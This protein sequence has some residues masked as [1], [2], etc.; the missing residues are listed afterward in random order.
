MLADVW[1]LYGGDQHD[2]ILAA[3]FQGKLQKLFGDKAFRARANME[4]RIQLRAFVYR[5]ADFGEGETV[6]NS[7][8][9]T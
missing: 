2:G 7:L 9:L 6:E 3:L 4:Q 1:D 5:R 8:K